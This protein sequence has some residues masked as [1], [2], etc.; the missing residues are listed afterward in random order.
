[1][2]LYFGNINSTGQIILED[3]EFR[4]LKVV[5][6]NVG[7]KIMI[8]D[9]TGNIYTSVISEINKHDCVASIESTE[10]QE[11]S[12]PLFHLAIAPTK[13]IDRIEWL[14]EK[15]VEL[16][17]YKISFIA[18]RHSERKD[19]KTERL[20]RIAIS[21]IKQSGKALLPVINEMQPFNNFLKTELEEQRLICA[22]EAGPENHIKLLLKPGKDA[23]ILIGPEGDF[24]E[25]EILAAKE[26]G[27]VLTS[28]G[29]ERLRT[30]TAAMAACVYFNFNKHVGL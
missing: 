9:G 8:T 21:A 17:L 7:E 11:I 28:L 22:M 10:I 16:G 2:D 3:D 18:C 30:E 1:M 14:L 24:H 13:N 5:R 20:K 6:K 25:S 12:R 19:V 15:C 27:F 4:H 23:V 26:N 29:P